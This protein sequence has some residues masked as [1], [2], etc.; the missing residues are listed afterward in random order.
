MKILVTGHKGFIG[1]KLFEELLSRDHWVVGIDK[2]VNQNLIDCEFPDVDVIFHLAAQIDVAASV[3]DPV[4]DCVNNIFPSVRLAHHYKDRRIIFPSSAAAMQ[5]TSP[6]G[7]SKKTGAEYIKMLCPNSVILTLPNVYGADGHSVIEKF[8]QEDKIKIYGDGSQTRD[9]VHADDIVTAMI[10]AMD[11]P[12]G[13]YM[14]GSDRGNKILD[15]AAWIGKPIKF[16]P[17]RPGEIKHSKLPNT[18][19]NWKPK[20]NIKEYVHEE[21]GRKNSSR[22]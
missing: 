10:D 4:F 18:T 16:L 3:K 7:L 15:I 17:E 5:I 20:I 8:L 14:L 6:Y 22:R 11:W 2:K 9:F 12:S 13:E 1:T 19:P 21:I